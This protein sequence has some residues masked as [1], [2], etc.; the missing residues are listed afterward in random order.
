M[1]TGKVWAFDPGVSTT[2]RVQAN[3]I[4]SARSACAGDAGVV[5][6]LVFDDVDERPS[7]VAATGPRIGRRLWVV[8]D[9]ILDA[10][11]SAKQAWSG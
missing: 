5:H 6:H 11:G 4:V 7:S 2:V 8:Q 1:P 3:V 9:G 10:T